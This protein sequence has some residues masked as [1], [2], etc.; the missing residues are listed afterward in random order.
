MTIPTAITHQ[1]IMQCEQ[2]L[3]EAM[4]S[5]DVE[6]LDKLLHDDLIFMI[7]NGQTVTKKADLDSHKAGTMTID[8][9]NLTFGEIA[10]I[11]DCAV[12]TVTMTASGKMLG[13]PL[14]GE[15]RYVRMWKK[16]DGQMKVIG[17]S[18]IQTQ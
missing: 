9:A 8:E 12:S 16:F 14:S 3:F 6:T 17:G 2:L 7:P 11:D 13:Q 4:R 10:L 15:F 1:E 5:S 18:C